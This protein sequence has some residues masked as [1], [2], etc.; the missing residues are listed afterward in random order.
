MPDKQSHT[1][2]YALTPL[3]LVRNL[4]I[5]LHTMQC[6]HHLKARLT[7][8]SQSKMHFNLALVYL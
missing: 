6:S 5:C 3:G 8:A 7:D 4:K 1:G 2:Y